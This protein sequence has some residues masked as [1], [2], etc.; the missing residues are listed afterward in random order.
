MTGPE[1]MLCL[2]IVALLCFCS[3]KAHGQTNEMPT[4]PSVSNLGSVTNLINSLTPT[5]AVAQK[6]RFDARIGYGVN[7]AS[8]QPVAALSVAYQIAPAL[9][10][11]GVVARDSIGITAGGLTLGINGSVDVPWIG[12]LDVFAGDGIA[13]DFQYHAPANYLFTGVEKPFYIGK[14][15]IAPGV[16]LANTST[17]AGTDLLFG[18]SLEF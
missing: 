1:F 7:I 6:Y 17:R 8:Q 10:I 18:C 15:R 9:A 2:L 16:S 13:Y 14:Y 4:F 3:C 12:E 5:A 11:G